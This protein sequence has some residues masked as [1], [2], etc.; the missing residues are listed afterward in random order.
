MP[1]NESL[2]S[3]GTESETNRMTG[4]E[5]FGLQPYSLEPTKSKVPVAYARNSMSDLAS[6][7]DA[8]ANDVDRRIGNKT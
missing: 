4:F 3:S 1:S 8:A 6:S 2:S 7:N 5:M